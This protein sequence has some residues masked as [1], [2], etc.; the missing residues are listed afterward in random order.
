[1]PIFFPKDL[2]QIFHPKILSTLKGY[3]SKTFAAD[4]MAGLIVG[5]VALP[6]AIAFGIASGVT[7]EQGLITAIIAGFLISLLGGSRVQ[8]GG[9]TGAFIV[10]VYGVVQQ[11]GVEGLLIATIMAGIM[12]VAMGVLQLGTIIKFMPYPIVV[13]FTS[14]IA[15]I[16]FSSQMRD[17]FGLQFEQAVPADF[18]GK[19]AFYFHHIST[20]NYF[21]LGIGLF[22]VFTI[23]LWPRVNKKI[24]GT[25][26]ALLVSTLAVLWLELPVETIGSK[27]GSIK[28]SIPM[29]A[30]PMV[31]FETIRL[32]LAP[33]FTIAMLG[34]IESLLS[35]MVADGATGGWHRSNT[36]LIGQG[37]ANI[38]T[39]LFGGIPATGAIAR[40]M[41]NIRNGGKTPVAGLVHA[42]TLFMILLFFGKYAILIPMST[43]AGILVMVAYN[44]SEWR[45]F[46]RLLKNSRSDVAVLLVTFL[47]TVVVDLTVAIQFGLLLAI[48][49]FLKRIIETSGVEVL[50]LEVESEEAELGDESQ[51]QSI[52]EGVEVFEINGPFFFGLAS[53]FE[54]AEKNLSKAPKV[55]I[56]R[57]RRVPFIDATGLNNMRNFIQLTQR[58]QVHIVLSGA[59]PVVN[60]ALQKSGIHALVGDQNNCSDI[61]AAIL[62]AKH[63]LQ[64]E[65]KSRIETKP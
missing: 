25:L 23:A 13:G 49:L 51:F 62:R 30:L 31:D 5:V 19:W 48:L 28:A 16:I 17:F 55:R 15:V 35:A 44:M 65:T 37:V 46:G 14:G 10:I 2:R 21:S 4:L 7:P 29:P 57:L 40:T 38:I 45:S 47:L 20:I 50:Q 18:V 36:E 22:T 26:I 59:V 61:E 3:D 24:P 6:L 53:K 34:A 8:I 27:F 1:M 52:P 43:L 60:E 32:L 12:L 58:K 42:F 56:I 63:L 39:P 54:E 64:M 41:T 11:F 9:P 33:A